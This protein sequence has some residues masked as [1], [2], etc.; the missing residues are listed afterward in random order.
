MNKGHWL[1]TTIVRHPELKKPC[2]KLGYCCY[3]QLVEE[4]PL[5][6]EATKYAIEQNKYSKLVKGQGWVSC[7]K[8]DE[9]AIPD[10]NYAIGKVE[11]PLECPVFGHDCPVHYHAELVQEEK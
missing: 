5:H 1:N 6:P 7:D 3:G 8:N 4:F 10:I 2:V 9:G 11:E